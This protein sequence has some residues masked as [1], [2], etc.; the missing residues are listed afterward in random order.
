MATQAKRR[1]AIIAE[2]MQYRLGIASDEA[3]FSR[4]YREA[5]RM[6]ELDA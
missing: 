2:S 6:P 4:A 1:A 5:L 3:W